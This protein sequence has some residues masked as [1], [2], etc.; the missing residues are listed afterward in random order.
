MTPRR[1]VPLW[2]RMGTKAVLAR[3]PAVRLW[4]D[5]RLELELDLELEKKRCVIAEVVEE[6]LELER[7]LNLRSGGRRT[8]EGKREVLKR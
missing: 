2:A 7:G 3:A 5:E 4:T 6:S 8:A 1:F